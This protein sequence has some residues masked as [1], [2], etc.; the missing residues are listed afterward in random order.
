MADSRAPSAPRIH[1]CQ[2][3][4]L[5]SVTLPTDRGQLCLMEGG[6]ERGVHIRHVPARRGGGDGALVPCWGD[7]KLVQPL[8][9]TV[10]RFL[11][12]LKTELARDPAVPLRVLI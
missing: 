10:H 9:T 4:A 3:P 6:K 8:C 2:G 11:T 12:Q 1:R 5:C 7:C